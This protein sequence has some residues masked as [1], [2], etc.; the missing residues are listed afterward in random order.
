[1]AKITST[2]GD[3]R[4]PRV[5]SR[6]DPSDWGLTEILTLRESAALYWPNGPLTERSLRTAVRDGTLGVTWIAGRLYTT[7]ESILAMTR[8]TNERTTRPR[9][10]ARGA[11]PPAE[12]EA[13]QVGDGKPPLSEEGQSLL[14]RIAEER[15]KLRKGPRKRE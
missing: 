13:A 6:P 1:M 5:K 10:P 2:T 15:A 12:G 11:E 3:R 8:C 7:K 4:P 14:L 9:R